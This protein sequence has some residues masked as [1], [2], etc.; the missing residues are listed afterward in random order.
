M[1][2]VAQKLARH[3]PARGVWPTGRGLFL[4]LLLIAFVF[5]ATY[6]IAAQSQVPLVAQA[7]E[8]EPTPAEPV[9]VSMSLMGPVMTG[10]GSILL[11]GDGL[12]P[13]LRFELEPAG[14]RLPGYDPSLFRP[15]RQAS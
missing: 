11:V 9:Q 1:R 14:C 13:I 6:S 5:P 4:I 3:R 2:R 8:H 12:F 10:D 15:P 7:D